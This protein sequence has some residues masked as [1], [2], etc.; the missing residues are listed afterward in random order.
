MFVAI[1]AIGVCAV[2]TNELTAFGPLLGLIDITG[3][4]ISADALHAPHR[5]ADY[6]TGRGAHYVLMVKRNQLNLHHQLRALPWTTIRSAG[7]APLAPPNLP[8]ERPSRPRR[9]MLRL[10][11]FS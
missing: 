8:V 3:A 11:I 7:R 2:L 5:H 6:R 10:L 1:L 4:I 9:S